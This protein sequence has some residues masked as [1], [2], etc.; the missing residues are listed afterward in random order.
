LTHYAD[1]IYCR[2]RRKKGSVTPSAQKAAIRGNLGLGAAN[3]STGGMVAVS[4]A[5]LV[6]ASA[7]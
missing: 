7:L 3:V 5:A 4:Y 6:Y 2:S 1:A